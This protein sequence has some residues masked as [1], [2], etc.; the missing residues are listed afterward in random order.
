MS[1]PPRHDFYE[2]EE[3]LTLSVYVRGADPEQVK[4]QF[5]DSSLEFS[6][7]ETTLSLSPLKGNIVPDSCDYT[8]GKVKVEIRLKKAT[9]GRW[10][11]LTRPADAVDEP[12]LSQFPTS[13]TGAP[14]GSSSRPRERKNW[15]KVSDNI[16]SS[17]KDKTS[18]EDPNAGGD[19]ALNGFF[20][21]LF[22]DADPDSQRAMMKSFVESGGT[23][24]STNWDE[25]K[26]E[27]VTVKPPDGSEWKKWGA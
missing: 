17:E 10:G 24:L 6:H 25:V 11:T 1:N 26:K 15:E 2:T 9:E 16:L 22:K 3:K 27:K 12:A 20:Q 14:S 5:T 7:G 21:T 18:N 8:V 13:S 4:V 19:A 23:T